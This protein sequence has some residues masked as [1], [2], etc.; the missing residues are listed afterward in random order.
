MSKD[1]NCKFT[2]GSWAKINHPGVLKCCNIGYIIRFNSISETL[3]VCV[4]RTNCKLGRHDPALRFE[5]I[6]VLGL[7]E[8]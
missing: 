7:T 2:I 1:Y 5:P 3:R 4:L 6:A 8:P